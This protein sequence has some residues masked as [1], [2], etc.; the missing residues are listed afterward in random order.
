M[1]G[2]ACWGLGN[3][4]VRW[5]KVPGGLG[6]TVWSGLVV[7]LPLLALSAWLDGPAVVAH[8]PD[9][10]H[11]RELAVHRLHRRALLLGRLRHLELAAPPLPASEVA[12][13][14]CSCRPPGCSPPSLADGERLTVAA[15]VGE[16]CS[17]WV[18][19]R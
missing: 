2:A 11:P 17:S 3:V 14:A 6:L 1:A 9:Q 18:S 5:L 12:P 13:P 10:P 19:L 4:L 8:A 7:P 15:S 16:F